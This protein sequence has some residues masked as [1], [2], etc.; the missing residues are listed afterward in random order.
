MAYFMTYKNIIT[1]IVQPEHS[2]FLMSQKNKLENIIHVLAYNYNIY[3][4]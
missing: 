2:N 4:I 3:I 1:I